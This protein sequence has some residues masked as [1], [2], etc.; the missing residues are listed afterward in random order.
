MTRRTAAPQI[1][2]NLPVKWHRAGF[3]CLWLVLS[4]FGNP[5]AL[6]KTVVIE[7]KPIEQ[8]IEYELSIYSEGKVKL[9]K[10][11]T[12]AK[13]KGDLPVGAYSYQIRGID[14]LKRPGEWSV[15]KSL[16]VMPPNKMKV[17]TPPDGEKLT[18]YYDQAPVK[19]SWEENAGIH[20]YDLELRRDG[21]LLSK[22]VVKGTEKN[23][24][25]LA[26][27]TYTWNIK[28]VLSLGAT[29]P[30]N[31]KGKSWE[32]PR[33]QS[34]E[35]QVVHKTLEKPVLISPKGRIAP[36]DSHVLLL[37]W[38]EVE[39][40]EGYWVKVARD[41]EKSVE[42]KA[43]SNTLAALAKARAYFSKDTRW[44]ARFSGE[45]KYVWSVRALNH[46]DETTGVAQAQS[47]EAF[48]LFNLDRNAILSGDLGYLA[49][50][51]MLAPYTYQLVS[52]ANNVQG[53][54][55]AAAAVFRAS[56]E[57]WVAPQWGIAGAVEVANLNL[58]GQ[59]FTRTQ[60]EITGKYRTQLTSGAYGWSLAPKLGL[61]IHGYN[62]IL[63]T[64]LN[65]SS[66]SSLQ[67]NDLPVWGAAVGF[68]LRKQFS[69]NLSFGMKASYFYPVMIQ[70]SSVAS[71]LTGDAS[72]RNFSVGIQGLYWISH[73]FGLGV[74]GYYDSRSLSFTP[75]GKSSGG[76]SEKIFMDGTYFFGS[77]IYRIWR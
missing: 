28:P 53:A 10:T 46:R 3:V 35:F 75:A 55:S 9:T 45:G 37:K 13:W 30:E 34:S 38:D 48:A 5:L 22:E 69:E 42:A 43:T 65:L 21:K 72:Y 24:E 64:V 39:G 57:F 32:A 41:P 58:S 31:L 61:E 68:D 74:G 17:L 15:W 66:T 59:S 73:Y 70:N 4:L 23:L 16:A 63:P 76:S 36:P 29:A 51:T 27:G 56:A 18:L 50:S 1:L 8:A 54:T 47:D 12:D 26:E 7:W 71:G 11:L 77:V 14:K 67:N 33:A 20:T 6:A 60:F 52:P 40:A 25:A 44:S 62:Y 2:K 19:L 49:L